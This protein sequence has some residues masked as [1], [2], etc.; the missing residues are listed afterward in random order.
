MPSLN[1]PT[2]F[3]IA[4]GLTRREVKLINDGSVSSDRK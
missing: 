4:S 1:L 3:V 2:V